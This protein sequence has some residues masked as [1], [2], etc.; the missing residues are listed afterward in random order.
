LI[1]QNE[2][3]MGEFKSGLLSN[4]LLGITFFA[5]GAAAIAMFYTL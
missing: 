1:A 2:K 3:V 4:I 5:M